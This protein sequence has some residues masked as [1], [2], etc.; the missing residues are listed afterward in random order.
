MKHLIITFQ[1]VFLLFSQNLIAQTKADTIHISHYDIHLDIR[2]FAQQTLQGYTDIEIKAKMAPLSSINLDFQTLSVDSVKRDDTALYFSRKGNQLNIS[3]PFSTVGQTETIRVYYHGK[4][5]NQSFGGFYFTSDFAYNMGVGIGSLP[6][7]LGRAWFPCIDEFTD[8]STYTF[9]I[10]TDADKKAICGGALVDSTYLGDKR[11]WKWELTDSVPTYLASVAVGKYRVY[12]DT[13]HSISGAVLPV[14]IYAD[15]ITLLKVPGSFVNLKTFIHTYENRWG[16]CHWQRVGYVVVP[17][18]S[19]AMEHATNISYPKYA[20]TGSTTNQDL[21]AHELAH[22]WFG[23]LITCSNSQNMWINEGF[24]TYGA[25]L[26]DETLDTTLQTYKTGIRNL[27]MNVLKKTHTADGGYFAL[28]NVPANVTYGSTSYDKGGLVAYTLRN[29]MGDELFFSSIKQFLNENKY[30]NVTSEEFFNKLSQ[31]SKME[32]LKDFYLGWVHQPGFL[33]FNIDFVKLKEGEDNIYQVAFRQRLHHA[34]YFA[35][36][37]K[38]DVEFVS[39]SGKRYLKQKLQFS[40]ET[41]TTDIELPFEPVFWAIDPNGAMGD[42]CY[43]YTCM[44]NKTGAT[45]WGDAY[46]KIQVTE[47]QDTAILRIEHNPFAPTPAGILPP[48][49]I[50]ISEKHFWRAGF[51]QYGTMQAQYAFSYDPTYDKELLQGY[52]KDNLSLLYR[53]DATCDWEMIPAQI[54]G[55]NQ[56]GKLETQFLLPGEYTLGICNHVKIKELENRMEIHPNPTAG[57]FQIVSYELEIMNIEV[58][59]VVGRKILEQKVESRKPNEIDIS[60]LQAGPYFIK[61]LTEKG[62]IIKK[63]IKY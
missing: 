36:N 41:D 24:A 32:E 5:F 35:N 29:Y 11:V 22:S 54:I 10:T 33:N 28:D 51:L 12:K 34:E 61:I 14:E 26:C 43:D 37:N 63:V 13:V 56:V 50:R 55:N 6:P 57:Q 45:S 25:L 38:V 46:F 20:V 1:I 44:I 62:N 53:K 21:I 8:R 58:F 27:H 48:N 60:N 40:G 3:L 16:A 9:S 52:T 39:A 2:N 31:I 59:D 7:S 19:G 4:P 49:I 23:N 17:F 42:A 30:K 47:I 15:S 18:N